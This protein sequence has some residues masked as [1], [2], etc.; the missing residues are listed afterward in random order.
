MAWLALLLTP[1]GLFAT[2]ALGKGYIEWSH[3]YS[4]RWWGGSPL[5]MA[6]YVCVLVPMFFGSL[7]G[8]FVLIAWLLP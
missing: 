7:I 3:K 4:D 5:W 8:P 2:F 6:G 1:I